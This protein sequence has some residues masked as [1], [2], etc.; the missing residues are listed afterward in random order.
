[1]STRISGGYMFARTI[2]N[3]KLFAQSFVG[4]LVQHRNDDLYLSK[5]SHITTSAASVSKPTEGLDRTRVGMSDFQSGLQIPPIYGLPS[6]VVR[7]RPWKTG[8]ALIDST[9]VAMN[10][11]MAITNRRRRFSEITKFLRYFDRPAFPAYFDKFRFSEIIFRRVETGKPN[12]GNLELQR[13]LLIKSFVLIEELAVNQTYMDMST[14]F[15]PVLG[16]DVEILLDG[17]LYLLDLGLPFSS[18][19]KTRMSN[20]GGVLYQY[21]SKERQEA[22]RESTA[23]YSAL[24]LPR[25]HT[26]VS[27]GVQDHR[28]LA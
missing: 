8:E 9:I 28:S 22:D 12:V 25:Y 18:K 14:T 27:Q 10:T 11:A 15:V 6:V 20:V 19:V 23:Y 13:A 3:P 7:Q 21:P 1:M 4:M 2:R 5:I 26:R 16:G 17:I 24:L